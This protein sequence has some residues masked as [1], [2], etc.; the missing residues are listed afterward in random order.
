[1]GS[2]DG[3]PCESLQPPAAK[4][5]D[6][7]FSV[8]LDEV[9][10]KEWENHMNDLE[11]SLTKISPM[12]GNMQRFTMLKQTPMPLCGGTTINI[13]ET[14]GTK[15]M[16]PS[17]HGVQYSNCENNLSTCNNDL[18]QQSSYQ[19]NNCMRNNNHNN[20]SKK[21]LSSLRQSSIREA[22]V[23]LGRGKVAHSHMGNESFRQLIQK[24]AKEYQD[25][26]NRSGKFKII[27]SVIEHVEN[28][29]GRFLKCVDGNELDPASWQPVSRAMAYEK[30][31]HSLRR[32]FKKE[33]RTTPELPTLQ[34]L[35][36][37]MVFDKFSDQ[38]IGQQNSRLGFCLNNNF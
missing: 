24:H 15:G 30:V 22:D 5:S 26:K 10:P 11:T 31:S 28:A 37:S 7:L 1:M 12:P 36:Q 6:S 18:Q 23:L 25:T 14:D 4:R 2:L 34:L 32:P 20:N 9:I 35:K 27:N 13:Q 8:D 29:G 16:I 17:G 33:S 21:A 38:M 19:I 3:V